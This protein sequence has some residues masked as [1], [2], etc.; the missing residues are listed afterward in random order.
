MNDVDRL[1]KEGFVPFKKRAAESFAQQHPHIMAVLKKLLGGQKNRVGIRVTE[2][3]K[4]V[5]EY[6]IHMEG[7]DITEVESGVLSS[8]L[9]HPFGIIIRPYVII[10]RSALERMLKEEENII[11]NPMSAIRKYLPDLTLKFM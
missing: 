9:H 3:G 10:E 11:S 5:G 2:N 6:T 8:E 4:M 7:T 1:I